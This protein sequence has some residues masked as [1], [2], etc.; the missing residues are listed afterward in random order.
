MPGRESREA[1]LPR[2][3]YAQAGTREHV[4]HQAGSIACVHTI[5]LDGRPVRT[6]RKA[7]LAVPGLA[8]ASAVAA[9]WQAQGERVDPATMPLTRFANSIIDGVVGHE[10][11]VRAD[12]LKYAASDLL[13]Y[14]AEGPES[15]VA[16]Q[17][18]AWDRVLAWARAALGARL[19]LAEGVMPVK[20]SDNAL[21]RIAEALAPLDAWTLT[22][23]HVL[24]TLTGSAILAL[25]HARGELTAVE[26]WTAAHV[27]EDWQSEQWGRDVEAAERRQRRWVELQS[28]S[29]LL[30]LCNQV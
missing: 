24:T 6:P 8:L 1:P 12:I 16:R 15:L 4:G 17:R 10:S 18:E 29:R 22:A 19:V 30:A 27:D 2:R 23:V 9:E 26:V 7:P 11:E 13:C 28:A 14:R 20:Q 25:A 21:S 5:T 3:F